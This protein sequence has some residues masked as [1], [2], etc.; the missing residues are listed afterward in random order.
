VYFS[1]N[2]KVKESKALVSKVGIQRLIQTPHVLSRNDYQLLL[3]TPGFFALEFHPV[4]FQGKLERELTADGSFLNVK[5]QNLTQ[6]QK[7]ALDQYIKEKGSALSWT[8]KSKR[9]KPLELKNHSFEFPVCAFIKGQNATKRLKLIDF[10][11]RGFLFEN[12][13]PGNSSDFIPKDIIKLSVYTNLGREIKNLLVKVIRTSEFTLKGPG[14]PPSCVQLLGL[15]LVK[16]PSQAELDYEILL[17]KLS[18]KRPDLFEE[19]SIEIA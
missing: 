4:P 7:D 3:R 15:E 5:F 16:D 12:K 19:P 17:E 8:R 9:I 2:G 18:E 13:L 11:D 14:L 10:N 1:W 6:N